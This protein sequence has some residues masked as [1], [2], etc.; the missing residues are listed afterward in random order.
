MVIKQAL[1]GF[2][3]KFFNPKN[4]QSGNSLTFLI[5]ASIVMGV[6]LTVTTGIIGPM[7]AK[8]RLSVS[9][10]RSYQSALNHH[11]N[12]IQQY[13]N[14]HPE[15]FLNNTKGFPT[16]GKISGASN[17]N[18]MFANNVTVPDPADSS[19]TITLGINHSCGFQV[20]NDPNTPGVQNADTGAYLT[21][22]APR[23]APISLTNL[24]Q[25]RS[26][27]TVNG[28]TVSIVTEL[29]KFKKNTEAG[30]EGTY[31]VEIKGYT[32]TEQ[33]GRGAT[34][35]NLTQDIIPNGSV[36]TQG[37]IPQYS[38]FLHPAN[39]NVTDYSVSVLS[40]PFF[41]L[42][43]NLLCQSRYTN[44]A[45]ITTVAN[46]AGEY[47]CTS[48]T[49]NGGYSADQISLLKGS[50]SA[51]GSADIISSVSLIKHDVPSARIIRLWGYWGSQGIQKDAILPSNLSNIDEKDVQVQI[52][53]HNGSSQGA[54]IFLRDKTNNQLYFSWAKWSNSGAESVGIF[55]NNPVLIPLD[56]SGTGNGLTQAENTFSYEPNKRIL[57]WV[58]WDEPTEHSVQLRRVIYDPLVSPALVVSDPNVISKILSTDL[59]PEVTGE[60]TTVSLRQTLDQRFE[61]TNTYANGGYRYQNQLSVN[62]ASTFGPITMDTESK[63]LVFSARLKDIRTGVTPRP[64]RY[65]IVGVSL[66]NTPINLSN[67]SPVNT[68][69]GSNAAILFDFDPA[70]AVAD[71]Q[72]KEGDLLPQP[73]SKLQDI[74]TWYD[75]FWNQFF[76]IEKAQGLAPIAYN[77][78]PFAPNT[79]PGYINPNDAAQSN[80]VN[81]NGLPSPSNPSLNG[82]GAAYVFQWSP[83]T[84][85]VGI[86]GYVG[87]GT[88]GKIEEWGTRA[89]RATYQFLSEA[90]GVPIPPQL[91]LNNKMITD[92]VANIYVPIHFRTVFASRRIPFV[93][94]GE[95]CHIPTNSDPSRPGNKNYFCP[96]WVGTDTDPQPT[97]VSN[98]QR[99]EVYI[100]SG[101]FL[102]LFFPSNN[103]KN[104]NA[105]IISSIATD[106][107]PRS[108][109]TAPNITVH[110]IT[111]APYFIKVG[112]ND[113]TQAGIYTIKQTPL[114]N[115]DGPTITSLNMTDRV[116]T[117][118]NGI[119]LNFNSTKRPDG[120][121]LTGIG[122]QFY[123]PTTNMLNM[124]LILS[125][126]GS[127]QGYN[128]KPY[129]YF[130]KNQSLVTNLPGVEASTTNPAQQR[131]N[132]VATGYDSRIR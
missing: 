81:Y 112:T 52:V 110:P 4:K 124:I 2:W 1:S 66:R 120:T 37:E 65:V 104:G 85:G 74:F 20:D 60:T 102:H 125:G 68:G 49:Y 100:Q 98:P 45:S 84:W 69:S 106:L 58:S 91:R 115:F 39:A 93:S 126:T 108:I 30:R 22:T 77:T 42:G 122:S 23:T 105:G 17:I 111:G 27:A 44:S 50:Q 43:Q 41:Q 26:T 73:V 130:V 67:N 127:T 10:G 7:I 63:F 97:I 101:R 121:Q 48:N 94:D 53:P 16:D 78:S 99:G 55:A 113:P 92:R 132:A 32:L 90:A 14:V 57:A 38:R 59:F 19:K 88:S 62:S 8:N 25:G 80:N 116:V 123:N 79:V 61:P 51:I 47:L 18:C 15:I 96:L 83:N 9:E 35:F 107:Y 54:I 29:T 40:G 114:Q 36:H 117:F 11:F 6:S 46:F 71:G 87:G 13:V 24:L 64:D 21:P 128:F 12:L 119:Q 129:S 76:W 31:S 86:N 82:R 28:L 75:P 3:S 131:I 5:T 33:G 95:Y 89:M 103:Y 72:T 34:N 118:N 56:A 109:P 70:T